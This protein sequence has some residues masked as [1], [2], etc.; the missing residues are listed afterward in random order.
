MMNDSLIT[1][2]ELSAFLLYAAYIGVAMGGKL[3]K[4]AKFAI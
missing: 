3:Y 2:G 4:H 1:I